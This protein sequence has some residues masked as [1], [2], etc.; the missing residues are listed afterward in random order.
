MHKIHEMNVE[1]MLCNYN[2]SV[3]GKIKTNLS[4][5]AKLGYAAVQ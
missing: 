2:G 3:A 4:P 5:T 1:K